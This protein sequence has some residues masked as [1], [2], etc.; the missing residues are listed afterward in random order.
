M[1]K[2]IKNKLHVG[3]TL[4]EMMVVIL[5]ISVLVLLFIPNLGDSKTKALE[6]SDKAIVATMRTQIELEE[7]EK[8]RTLTPEEEAD[9]FPKGK[10]KELYEAKIK[11][12]R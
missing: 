10:K 2:K 7:F 8:G 11:G 9:L 6:E 5:I 3:F 12:K 1:F 4:V